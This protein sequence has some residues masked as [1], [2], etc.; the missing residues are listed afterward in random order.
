MNSEKTVSNTSESQKDI[1]AVARKEIKVTESNEAIDDE[2]KRSGSDNSKKLLEGL[3]TITQRVFSLMP[4]DKAVSPDEFTSAGIAISEA[5][6]SLTMLELCGLVE[7]LPGGT[8]IR[9]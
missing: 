8:Y 7:S 2:A 9:K 1:G 6:T 5:I 3:D 4:I